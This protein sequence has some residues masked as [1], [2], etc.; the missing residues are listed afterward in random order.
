MVGGDMNMVGRADQDIHEAA[1]LR[2][3]GTD[4]PD[5]LTWGFQPRTGRW[6]PKRLDR[7]FYTPVPGF[8]VEPVKVIGKGLKTV[9]GEWAS[10]HYGLVST[11]RVA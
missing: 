3:A 6:A 2:D 1:G 4:G 8:T 7:V 11:L 10:D 5:S 9:R